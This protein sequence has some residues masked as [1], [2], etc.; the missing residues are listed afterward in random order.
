MA[1]A[2]PF[3]DSS[4]VCAV[5][6]S[7]C[8]L[9]VL[10][11]L[12]PQ[13]VDA[14]DSTRIEFNDAVRIALEQNT[15]LKR[16]SNEVDRADAR[17]WTERMDWVPTADLSASGQRRFG[18]SFSQQEGGIINQ[19]TDELFGGVS[20]SLRLQGLGIHNWASMRQAS[21]R[22]TASELGLGRT[23]QDVVFQVMNRYISLVEN[24][25]ILRVQREELDARRQQLRQI[26]EFVNAGSR[27][28]SALY[29]QQAAVAEAE[30]NV[31]VAERDV[32]LSETRL[33]QT[34]RL[35]P[36][37]AYAFEAPSLEQDTLVGESY[38]MRSLMQQAFNRRLD[39][40]A[41]QEDVRA[42]DQGVTAAR[43]QYYPT[44]SLSAN[45]NT[46]WSSVIPDSSVTFSDSRTL[47]LLTQEG[48]TLPTQVPAGERQ[49]TEFGFMDKL[50]N[51][52]GG[53]VTLSLS[54]PLFNGLVR[55]QQIEEAKVAEQNARYA[56]DDQELQIAL[57]VREAYLNY[58]TAT[59]QLEVTAK[60]LRS[61]RQA[62]EAAQERYN[63]GAASI[64]E[65]TNANRTFVQAAS[66]RVQARYNFI[67]QQ[68]LIDY[69]TGI[70]EPQVD[71]F[72]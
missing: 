37:E 48:V 10:C 32:Q 41:A 34:L 11:L 23:R 15:T 5:L 68:K 50:D 2:F 28:V 17:L 64:V 1:V 62:R 33:I 71:L 40:R 69:Y 45:Y 4:S 56:R 12:L 25:E 43:S 35:D 14:Q 42:A 44:L 53:S 24:R 72:E 60:Q 22:S 27:P 49:V 19:S 26:E 55:E 38:D 47:N 54:F 6:R 63:L 30:S 57:E 61:A 18:R 36:M 29:E 8:V 39:L 9:A 58:Q 20:S 65:L 51:R 13:A 70:L 3:R 66:Q 46:S 7:T 52:R 67:F 16:A 21:S 59:K 31:L